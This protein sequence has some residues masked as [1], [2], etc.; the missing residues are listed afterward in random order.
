MFD[1]T[2]RQRSDCRLQRPR[3]ASRQGRFQ[4][5]WRC[6]DDHRGR[7][8]PVGEL[9]SLSQAIDRLF[10]DR[11]FGR[12]ATQ[13]APDHMTGGRLDRDPDATRLRHQ[14]GREHCQRA[15]ANPADLRGRGPDRTGTYADEYPPL[16]RKRHPAGPLDPSPHPGTGRQPRR[17]PHPLRARRATGD[18]DPG[19]PLRRGRPGTR[20]DAERASERARCPLG[21]TPDLS[22]MIRQQRP[23]TQPESTAPINPTQTV[24]A[25]AAT[26][27]RRS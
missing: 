27:N 7:P 19:G 12:T 22:A 13:R 2:H 11:L 25:A 23:C 18:A 17:R 3:Q 5:T 15:S 20:Q 6:H 4:G 9:P 8:S 26:R 10:E 16:Q 1:R 14:R 21:S 24:V